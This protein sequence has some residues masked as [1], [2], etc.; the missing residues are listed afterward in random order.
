MCPPAS[1]A[2]ATTGPLAGALGEYIDALAAAVTTDQ[3]VVAELVESVAKLTKVNAELVEAVSTLTK[4][5]EV[6]S[7]QD[8]Q[9]GKTGRGGG[10]WKPKKYE[11]RTK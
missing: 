6:L 7:T 11:S 3:N 9:G 1:A 5:N 10:E 2:A 4:A 8:Q